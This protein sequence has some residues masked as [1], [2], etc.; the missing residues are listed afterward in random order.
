[1]STNGRNDASALM[2]DWVA[3][4]QFDIFR[5]N[6]NGIKSLSIPAYSARSQ[7]NFQNGTT[8]LNMFS[9]STAVA[10]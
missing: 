4:N 10:Y 5:V 3:T 9:L 1:M 6:A 7:Q 8:F 2:E